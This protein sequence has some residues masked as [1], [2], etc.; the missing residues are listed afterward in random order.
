MSVLCYNGRTDQPPL[1]MSHEEIL[2]MK[3]MSIATY[4]KECK[5][6]TTRA[7]RFSLFVRSLSLRFV[8]WRTQRR[9]DRDARRRRAAFST[10]N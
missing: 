2:T 6:A 4:A 8:L 7:E 3:H 9:M 5:L 1:T 10:A